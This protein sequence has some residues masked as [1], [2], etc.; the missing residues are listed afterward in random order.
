VLRFD[1]AVLGYGKK[2]VISIP[3][4]E[5]LPGQRVIIRGDNGSGKSTVFRVLLGEADILSGTITLFG[6]PV[7]PVPH[8]SQFTTQIA[9]MTQSAGLFHGLSVREHLM[10][11][12]SFRGA[13]PHEWCQKL[14]VG[15]EEKIPLSRDV[16]KLSGGQR[17]WLSLT[18][19]LSAPSQLLLLDEPFAGLS[20]AW[21]AEAAELIATYLDGC[22]ATCLIIEHRADELRAL[23]CT[24][25]AIV[26]R[27]D[28]IAHLV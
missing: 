22:G 16:A 19:T 24:E 8:A 27:D 11:A 7:K 14:M 23:G 25:R 18:A 4:F 15:L 28:D 13:C 21:A 6:A 3:T 5:I 9:Y 2:P 10:L 26:M 20:E 12:H 17:R 1:A